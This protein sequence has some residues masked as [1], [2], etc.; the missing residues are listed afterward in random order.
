MTVWAETRSQR[1]GAA[2]RNAALLKA[3]TTQATYSKSRLPHFA[4]NQHCAEPKG[5]SKPCSKRHPQIMIVC[6][7]LP[8]CG[9]K[10]KVSYN[11]QEVVGGVAGFYA[12]HLSASTAL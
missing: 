1:I 12:H 7:E 9:K 4:I 6:S 8:D 11:L 2:K 5:L 10:V 3:K